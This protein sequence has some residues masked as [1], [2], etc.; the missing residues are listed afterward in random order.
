MIAD[1]HLYRNTLREISNVPVCGYCNGC[2]A[3]FG[4]MPI[5]CY[6][7]DIRRERTAMIQRFHE[8]PT[9]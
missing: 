4:G 7:D 9:R 8:E 3:R 6:S 1:P 5:D 2:I